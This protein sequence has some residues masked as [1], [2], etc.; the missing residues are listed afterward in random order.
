MRFLRWRTLASAT[1]TTLKPMRAAHAS[2]I[3]MAVL[4]DKPRS[5]T[6]TR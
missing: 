4:P 1:K 2:T 5:N 3:R 6:A